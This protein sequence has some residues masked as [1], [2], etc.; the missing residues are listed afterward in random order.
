MS[1]RSVLLGLSL[2]V[3]GCCIASGQQIT[4]ITSFTQ[5]GGSP[6]CPQ[7]S[8]FLDRI[9]QQIYGAANCGGLLQG[10]YGWG[11]GALYRIPTSGGVPDVLY[12]FQGEYTDSGSPNNISKILYDP[13]HQVIIG[14][15]GTSGGGG[16]YW[17]P[18]GIEPT[19]GTFFQTS[20]APQ[21][22]W[23]NTILKSIE[24]SDGGLWAGGLLFADN[25]TVFGY[26]LHRCLR[27]VFSTSHLRVQG[28]GSLG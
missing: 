26:G 22:A 7:G 11:N 23:Q 8:V 3:V 2:I 25:F 6:H 1:R 14:V 4:T 20:H 21:G 12:Y 16:R 19:G 17:Q 28:M 13:T 9:N 10:T 27:F 5:L 15:V 24:S 18:D